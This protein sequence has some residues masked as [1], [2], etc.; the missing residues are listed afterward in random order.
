MLGQSNRFFLMGSLEV[1]E[2]KR[3]IMDRTSMAAEN[4]MIGMNLSSSQT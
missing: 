1:N 2:G 4:P 3:K